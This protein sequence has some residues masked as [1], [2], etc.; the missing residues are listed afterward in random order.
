MVTPVQ[1]ADP[2]THPPTNSA[3]RDTLQLAGS[4]A[5]AQRLPR[6]A[7]ALIKLPPRPLLLSLRGT[8]G[9]AG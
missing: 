8:P 6:S 1:Q 2:P 5:A 4:L 7:A 3:R 9:P